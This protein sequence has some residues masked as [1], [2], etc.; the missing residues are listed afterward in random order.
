VSDSSAAAPAPVPAPGLPLTLFRALRPRQWLKNGVLFV[1]LMF[2]KGAFVPDRALKAALAVLAFSLLAS[3]VYVLNDWVD[4]EHDRRHPEKRRRPIAAGHLGGRGAAL[5]VVLCWTGAGLLG[6]SISLG[7][8]GVLGLY[9]LEQ[10]LYSLGLKRIVILDIMAI[11]LG[12][13]IRVVAGA[14][15]IDVEVSSW[16][17]LC[18]LFLSLFLGFAKRRAELATLN[19]DAVAHRPNLGEYSVELLDQMMA[20]SAACSILSY[21]LYT[22][23]HET[24][25][26]LGS[27]RLTLTVPCVVYGVF[28]YL[29][30]VHRRGAG[31]APEKVLLDDRALQVSV[32]VYLAIAGWALYFPP[33]L[34]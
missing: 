30:L 16:L 14:V 26:R 9:L 19:Q 2:A 4:R 17:F 28:R 3:G 5:L 24:V 13:I 11:A 1:P 20:V 33:S 8:L 21:S 25:V 34:G 6:A 10:V 12:F 27:H 32:G 18:T 29:F 7:L 22:S 31:G 23:A 15:A